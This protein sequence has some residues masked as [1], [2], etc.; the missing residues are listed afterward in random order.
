MPS[1]AEKQLGARSLDKYPLGTCKAAVL[2]PTETAVNKTDA[3]SGPP[4][5]NGNCSARGK[6]PPI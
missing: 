5:R 2:V 1:E 3:R 4:T 6:S